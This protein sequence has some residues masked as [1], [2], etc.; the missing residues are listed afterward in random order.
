MKLADLEFCR[1]KTADLPGMTNHD[2][3]LTKSALDILGSGPKPFT[4]KK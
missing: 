4:V 1:Y 3:Q 2:F